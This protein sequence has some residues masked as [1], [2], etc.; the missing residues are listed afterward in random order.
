ME[1]VPSLLTQEM[2]LQE[3]LILVVAVAAGGNPT[4][5]IMGLEAM[6]VLALY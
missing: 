3:L 4:G 6:A 2:E 5:E 1:M